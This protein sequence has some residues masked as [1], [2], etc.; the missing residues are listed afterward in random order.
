MRRKLARFLTVLFVTA[1]SAALPTATAQA[2]TSCNYNSTNPAS[3]SG[4]SGIA[5]RGSTYWG[6]CHTN[7][8]SVRYNLWIHCPNGLV[9]GGGFTA[10]ASGTGGTVYTESETCWFGQHY[11]FAVLTDG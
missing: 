7:G 6:W 9:G 11:D 4:N 5:E 10:Y 2:N 8:G 3:N 1:T